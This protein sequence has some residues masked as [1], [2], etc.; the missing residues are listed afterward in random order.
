M[1][2][3]REGL[4]S[5]LRELLAAA[6]QLEPDTYRRWSLERIRELLPGII[7]D[8]PDDGGKRGPVPGEFRMDGT[9][10]FRRESPEA[11]SDDER[12]VLRLAGA[13][14]LG[15]LQ[16][17]KQL[18]LLR[19]LGRG[20]RAA[21]LVDRR[22]RVHATQGAFYEALRAS[23]PE[24]QDGLLPSLLCQPSLPR[25]TMQVRSHQWIVESLG[26]FLFV[27]AQPAGAAA[28]LTAREQAVAAAVLQS[29]SQQE[30]ARCLCVSSHTVRNTLVR[31]YSKLGVR[32]RV[33]LALRFKP[34]LVSLPVDS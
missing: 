32:N 8:W 6:L 16:T 25:V 28:V 34:E 24:W 3:T 15:G 22:G 27:T 7:A 33:E 18:T 31:V 2:R 4:H 29:S 30:V 21:A 20:R 1:D 14:A 11:L 19:E 26:S 9:L 23:W 17:S 12:E 13:Q 5:C 10:A